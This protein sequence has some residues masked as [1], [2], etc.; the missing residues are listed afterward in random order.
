MKKS[1]QDKLQLPRPPVLI[2]IIGF[3]LYGQTLFFDYTNFDD[4]LRIQNDMHFYHLI[5]T[6]PKGEGG[7]QFVMHPSYQRYQRSVSLFVFLFPA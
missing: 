2:S 6:F 3:L 4:V 5:P 1:A 7:V